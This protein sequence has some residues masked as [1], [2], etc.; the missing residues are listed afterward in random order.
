MRTIDGPTTLL[1]H[2]TTPSSSPVNYTVEIFSVIIATGIVNNTNSALVML[3]V[4]LVTES[5]DYNNRNKGILVS[6]DSNKVMTLFG[7]RSMKYYLW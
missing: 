4:S 5:S 7:Y 3:S 6:S 2:I 1:L